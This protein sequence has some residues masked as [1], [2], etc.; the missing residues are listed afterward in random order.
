MAQATPSPK[1]AENKQVQ[2]QA[3]IL[4]NIEDID[5]LAALLDAHSLTRVEFEDVNTHVVL[6]RQPAPVVVGAPAA[7][8]AAP[9]AA[10]LPGD[11]PVAPAPAAAPDSDATVVRSPLVGLVYRAR[12]PEQ[13]PFVAVGQQVKAGDVLCLIEAMKLFNEITAPVDG[14]VQQIHFENGALVEYDAPLFTLA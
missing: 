7:A 6:E 13:P 9:A 4:A 11:N 5:R 14:T 10:A 8:P 2:S 3:S 1:G 12:D